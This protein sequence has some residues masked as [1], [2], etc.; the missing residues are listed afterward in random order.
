MFWNDDKMKPN[1]KNVLCLPLPKF[2]KNN[3]SLCR[4]DRFAQKNILSE[5]FRVDVSLF[6]L[7][8]NPLNL[9]LLR[10]EEMVK[11]GPDIR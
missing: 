5:R 11:W 8:I 10:A 2:K 4:I 9:R 1:V 6:Q 3:A 7:A